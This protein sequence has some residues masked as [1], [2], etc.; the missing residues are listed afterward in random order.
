MIGATVGGI[1]NLIAAFRAI[2]FA[3]REK[4]KADH[5]FWL[6]LFISLYVGSYILVFTAFGKAFTLTAAI[7]ELLPVIAMTATTFGFRSSSAKIIRRFS[8][9]SS[10]S[11]LVY[12]IVNVSVGAIICEVFSLFSIVIGMLRYDIKKDRD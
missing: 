7:I 6:I 12:N 4:F 3:N 9:I 2:I 10:P 1:L 8:L 5:L 11:W